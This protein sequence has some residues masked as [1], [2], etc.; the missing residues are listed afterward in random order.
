M[1]VHTLARKYSTR[2]VLEKNISFDV[3][4]TYVVTL[5]LLTT[6]YV[7][8]IPYSYNTSPLIIMRTH[9]R[10]AVTTRTLPYI[11]PHAHTPER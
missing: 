5:L 6:I 2:G 1:A 7:P 9:A 3:L 10:D 4:R 11:L 8:T